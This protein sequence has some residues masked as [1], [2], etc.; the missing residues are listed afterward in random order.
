MSENVTEEILERVGLKY[1]DL[2]TAE[3]ETLNTWSEALES[4]KLTIEIVKDFISSMRDSVEDE[5]TKTDYDTKQDLFLKARLRNLKLLE[6]FLT[7]P[8]KAKAALNRAIASIAREK[9]V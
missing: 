8:E 6:A 1:D 5:L 3:R 9:V 4:N 2:S 7:S